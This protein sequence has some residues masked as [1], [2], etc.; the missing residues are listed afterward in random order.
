MRCVL[1]SS[2]VRWSDLVSS[3]VAGLISV[4]VNYG[5]TFVL[6]LQAAKAADLIP[7]HRTND[8][9]LRGSSPTCL[10]SAAVL[11]AFPA[12]FITTLTGLVLLDT[13]DCSLASA[14]AHAVLNA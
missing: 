12:A 3:V 2:F 7:S 13:N 4:I 1:S 9:S 10:I 14:V 5:G 6:M 8:H 11:M